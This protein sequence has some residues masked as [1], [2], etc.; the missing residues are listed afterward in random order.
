MILFN[1]SDLSLYRRAERLINPGRQGIV[2]WAY[3]YNITVNIPGK[4]AINGIATPYVTLS[5]VRFTFNH[6]LVR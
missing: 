1:P 3:K 6:V 5:N 4:H 2:E